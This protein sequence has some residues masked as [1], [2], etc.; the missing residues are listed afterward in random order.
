VVG[1][2]S[3]DAKKF[4]NAPI[5]N[6]DRPGGIRRKRMSIK[7]AIELKRFKEGKLLTRKQAILAQCYECNGYEAEDCLGVSCPLYQWSPYT[8]VTSLIG[9]NLIK[10]LSQ[11][12]GKPFPGGKNTKTTLSL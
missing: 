11:R 2:G 7:G 8:K 5:L 6:V 12:K 9:L 4:V 3:Q 1:R 10:P